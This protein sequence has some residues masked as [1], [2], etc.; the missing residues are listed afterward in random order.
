MLTAMLPL[1]A[2]PMAAAATVQP[3]PATNTVLTLSP[4]SN[5]ID[6]TKELQGSMC[7]TPNT[8]VPVTWSPTFYV[9]A[10]EASLDAAMKAQPDAP[11]VVFGYSQGAE[12][13][14]QWLKNHADDPD[15]PD[16]ADVT[17][18]LIGNPTRVYG[19]TGSLFGEV[20]PQTDYQVIDISREYDFASDFPNKP[21]SPFYL[22]AI[23]N[24]VAGLVTVHLNYQDVN[25]DDPA[26]TEWKVGNTTYIL[27][28]TPS[29]PLLAPLQAMGINTS[30]LNAVLKPLVDS[31][32]DRTYGGVV[33]PQST[34]ATAAA[35]TQ[36]VPSAAAVES[37]GS[38]GAATL[39]SRPARPETSEPAPA[40]ADVALTAPA[41]ASA[42][43]RAVDS[44]GAG[45]ST[46]PATG[47]NKFEP[48]TVAANGS[49][50]VG[51]LNHSGSVSIGHE[52]G[53]TLGK[54]VKDVKKAATHG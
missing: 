11:F 18:V 45:P 23:A 19:G 21:S 14:E 13:V 16:P 46:T 52:I 27:V 25:V 30:A 53:F 35:S 38:T 28:P 3:T 40:V 31:A 48:A 8:C 54:I 7:R 5:S 1:V 10:G 51:G 47:G 44:A 41:D 37:A 15:A 17:F 2:V 22:L 24:A 20:V 12:V 32:Y 49:T 43:E 36:S 33:T 26:N 29:L 42:T 4:F 9:P 39:P 50:T 6:M 34:T